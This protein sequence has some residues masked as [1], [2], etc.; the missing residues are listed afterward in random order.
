MS[1]D[2]AGDGGSLSLH[3]VVPHLGNAQVVQNRVEFT[4]L[5]DFI[6]A[7]TLSYVAADPTGYLVEAELEVVVIGEKGAT[8]RMAWDLDSTAD[9]KQYLVSQRNTA[10]PFLETVATFDNDGSQRVYL[11]IT[12]SGDYAFRV[13]VVDS[14]GE[15]SDWSETVHQFITF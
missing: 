4:P 3:S 5:P 7:E 10:M 8:V 9:V 15:R 6:G 12:S 2:L 11:N 1:N 13:A 14:S